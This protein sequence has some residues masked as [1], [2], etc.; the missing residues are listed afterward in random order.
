MDGTDS[1]QQFRD[2]NELKIFRPTCR[3][4]L[5]LRVILFIPS[6]ILIN[7]TKYIRAIIQNNFVLLQRRL[8]EINKNTC[9]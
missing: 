9:F 5:L 3:C 1:M 2:S 8:L 4:S 6:I 7:Q